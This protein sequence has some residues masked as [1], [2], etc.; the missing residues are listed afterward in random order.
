MT[1]YFVIEWRDG[2]KRTEFMIKPVFENWEK[3][4]R[5]YM[6]ERSGSY[7]ILMARLMGLRFAD[8]LRFVRDSMGA[9]IRGKGSIY[10]Y[11]V[12]PASSVNVVQDFLNDVNELVS[13]SFKMVEANDN[14][15]T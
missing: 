10:C 8:Y 12:F 9:E 7:N 11:P 13:H 1:E 4:K 15:P 3:Y 5:M 6:D 14:K 2:N